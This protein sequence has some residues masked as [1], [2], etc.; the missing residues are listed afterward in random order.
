MDELPGHCATQFMGY[1]VVFIK[2]KTE[3][4]LTGTRKKSKKF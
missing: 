4:W 2:H 1:L 3:L